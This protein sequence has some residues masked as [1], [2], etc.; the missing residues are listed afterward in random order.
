MNGCWE[1]SPGSTDERFYRAQ[2]K[3]GTELLCANTSVLWG[4]AAW[5]WMPAQ[6]SHTSSQQFLSGLIDHFLSTSNPQWTQ[7][8]RNCSFG[9]RSFS[10]LHEKFT[11]CPLFQVEIIQWGKSGKCIPSAER[12]PFACYSWRCKSRWAL[13]SMNVWWFVFVFI[14]G[15]R[16]KS[17]LRAH[18]IAATAADTSHHAKRTWPMPAPLPDSCCRST[19]SASERLELLI[20]VKDRSSVPTLGTLD[21]GV[22]GVSCTCA[23]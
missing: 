8:E 16:R 6:Q 19:S 4:A 15:W 9:E 7:K 13:T 22:G 21:P 1:R 11:K 10:S 18:K 17:A 23:A 3:A 20:W 12:R 2:G 14:P 5:R